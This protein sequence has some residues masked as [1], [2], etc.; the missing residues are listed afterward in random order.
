MAREVRR[1]LRHGR[2]ENWQSYTLDACCRR[3]GLPGKNEAG[4]RNAADAYGADP[5]S[6]MWLLPARHVGPYAEDDAQQTLEL[7][8]ILRPRIEE[9]RLE[10]AYRLEVDL[11]PVVHAMRARG[12][13]I[14]TTQAELVQEMM[15]ARVRQSTDEIARLWGRRCTMRDL[16]SPDSLGALFQHASVQVPLTPK[17]RKPSVTR[18]FLE[19]LDHPLGQLVRTA[20]Q[21]DDMAEKFVGTYI[22]GSHHRGR[23]HAEIHQ[24]RDDDGGTRSYRL[25]YS[26]PPLQQIPARDPILAPP[27]RKIFEAELG[28]WWA[29]PDYSQQEPRLAVHFAA[30]LRLA[31]SDAAVDY[32]H[33]GTDADFHTMVALLAGIPRGSAKIINLGLMYG[34]GLAKLARSLGLSED[35]AAQ[36]METYHQRVPWVRGLTDACTS[37]AQER[38]WVRLVDG[39]RCRFDLWEP[40]GTRRG[41]DAAPLRREEAEE[42]ERRWAES[43]GRRPRRLRRAG[44]HKAMNRLVQGSAAR[45]TKMA[46]LACAREGLLP[47]IQMHDEIGFSVGS[48]RE[49]ERAAEIMRSVVPLRIPVKVDLEY[50]RSWGHAKHTWEDR[51]AA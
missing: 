49:G 43:C 17:T 44:T 40:T 22:L 1:H 36:L 39:A 28:E 38:G 48:E 31:G 47:L 46:M 51:D 37:L 29:A 8:A 45:Q 2:D 34:M 19:T 42:Q 20:R 21:A 6:Q 9:E 10:R 32:Y 14:S 15:R 7:A 23:I 4:L 41:D 25:S 27:I 24:L 13:R 5:K 16:R 35:E 12:I 33:Q 3:E 30:L 11:V 18:G 26:S 50:G